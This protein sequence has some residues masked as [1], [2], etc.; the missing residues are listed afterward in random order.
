MRKLPRLENHWKII[1][2][3]QLG[4]IQARNHLCSNQVEW[5]DLPTHRA[6]NNLQKVLTSVVGPNKPYIK[7]CSAPV[8]Q[9]LKV[10]FE[11]IKLFSNNIAAS[12]DKTPKYVKEYKTSS[13]MASSQKL[14][15]IPPTE[16]W[17][18]M[19]Y[20]NITKYYS[21]IK[22]NEI[23]PFEILKKQENTIFS[24]ERLINKNIPEKIQMMYLARDI[25]LGSTSMIRRSM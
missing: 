25:Q 7:G 19:W 24:E 5:K 12:Q 14:G 20:I 1:N 9:S 15:D 3:I 6:L 18:K 11:R 4:V 23:M 16:E 13:T 2:R 8:Q 10:S 17:I 22:K 21:V